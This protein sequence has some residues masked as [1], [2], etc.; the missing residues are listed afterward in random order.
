MNAHLPPEGEQY[1]EMFKAMSHEELVEVAIQLSSDAARLRD[2]LDE[3]RGV[4]R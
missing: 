4:L 1:R 3:E 2:E